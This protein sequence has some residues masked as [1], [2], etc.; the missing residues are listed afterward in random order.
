MYLNCF[1]ELVC[2]NSSTNF[3]MILTISQNFIHMKETEQE[4]YSPREVKAGGVL[5]NNKGEEKYI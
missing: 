3:H 5:S 2:S 4:V 1:Y